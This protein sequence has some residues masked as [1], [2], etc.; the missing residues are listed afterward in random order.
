[1]GLA[2]RLKTE[3][4]NLGFHL[5]G[6]TTPEPPT[7]VPVYESWLAEGHHGEMAY[8]AAPDARQR[9][10][11]PREILP[12]CQSILVLG[13]HYSPPKALSLKPLQGKIAAY[14]CNE[15][16]HEVLKLRLQ[17]LVAF[18][19][20]E[21]GGSIPNRFYTDTG[22]VL[23]RDLAQRAGL[24]WIGR[25]S[26][27]INPRVGSYFL[28]A[29]IFLGIPLEPDAPFNSDHCGSCTRCVDACPTACILPNR[30]L[31]AR[32]C[33]SYWTIEH[34][35]ATPVSLRPY[36][37]NWVFG[38][39]ICQQ[40]CPWNRRFAPPVGDPA[41]APRSHLPGV[42]LLDEL[43]LDQQVF[44]RSYKG[45]PI[46]RAK[47]RG[48]LRNVAVALGNVKDPAAIPV[49]AQSL[50]QDPEPL[51][52]GHVAWALGQIRGDDSVKALK[53]ALEQESVFEV[54]E[55][56]IAALDFLG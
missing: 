30:T 27:L 36:Q 21:A 17:A 15:D 18:L 50:L 26:M 5:V 38:C 14:A 29:E 41:F 13:I 56:I 8:L 43:V 52:R 33:I 49:L 45:S 7:S 51:V 54:S 48:Y 1:M 6:I 3:A 24:G 39:D 11:D 12:E 40:V 31:D 53:Q 2:T 47:R 9:R 35:G 22:P 55:E 16:Y 23:E 20:R 37:G 46:K 44:N 19:E 32:H 42:E 34:K 25:N 10:A 28:L 4:L